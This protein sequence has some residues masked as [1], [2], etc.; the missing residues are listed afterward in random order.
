MAVPQLF[1]ARGEH[2]FRKEETAALAAA[3]RRSR[4]VI[5]LGGGAPET[6]ANRLLLEQTPASLVIYLSAPLGTLTLRCEAQAAD[7]SQTPRPL[8]ADASKL[9]AR[10]RLRQPLYLRLAPHIAE[11]EGESADETAGKVL[12]LIGL[13]AL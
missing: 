4:V 3:L 1:T 12:S 5:A 2:G 6:L 7:A 13:G 10:F 9:E 8:L 11:T